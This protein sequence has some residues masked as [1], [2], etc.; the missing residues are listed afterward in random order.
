MRE[1]LIVLAVLAAITTASPAI[2][3]LWKPTPLQ[4]AQDY[5]LINHNKGDEGRV[6]IQW[7]ASPTVTPLTL[8]QTLDKYVVV[9]ITHTRGGV[10]GVVT[11]D[12]IE[13]VQAADT[14][15]QPLKELPSD[16]VPPALI[17]LFGAMEAT[18]NRA[19][20]GK[21]KVRWYVFEPAQVAACAPGKLSVTYDG[22]TYTFDTPIPGCAKS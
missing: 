15:G 16:A 2:A 10:G 6:I 17:S 11:W 4:L 9:G 22:E 21:A 5:T 18:M 1:R 3:R 8:R 12:D 7:M 14:A 13:G 20:Q 19:S